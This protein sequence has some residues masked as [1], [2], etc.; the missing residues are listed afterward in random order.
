[1]AENV[2]V[3]ARTWAEWRQHDLDDWDSSTARASMRVIARSIGASVAAAFISATA[4]A[5]TVRGVVVDQS[6]TPVPGVVVQLLD[7]TSRVAGRALSNE[8]GEFR[9]AATRAGT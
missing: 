9:V 5:Q 3:L 6:A 7:S 1:M 8:R 2:D 4:S